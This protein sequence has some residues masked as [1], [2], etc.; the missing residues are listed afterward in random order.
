MR[1]LLDLTFFSR[2]IG[3]CGAID[4][5]LRSSDLTPMDF[6]FRGTKKDEIFARKPRTVED[7]IQFILGT[8]Q[9]I[10][11]DKDLC[12]GQGCGSGY[13]STASAS[14]NKKRE[15]DR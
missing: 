9:E 15:N 12:S 1:A 6:F 14:N 5:L 13:F 10:D 2:W 11:T 8:C 7:M 4:W 3:R